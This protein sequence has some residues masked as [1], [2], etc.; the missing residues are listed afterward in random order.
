MANWLEPFT[1]GYHFARVSRETGYE[2]GNVE[3]I[4]D[5]GSITRNVDT[6]SYE[7]GSFSYVGPLDL[8]NDLVRP[9]L[10]ATFEDGTRESVPLGTF[11][12]SLPSSDVSGAY[13]EGK[14][15]M[16]GRLYE[17]A[18]ARFTEPLR[19][20]KGSN[21][22]DV[23][24]MVLEDAG[25]EVIA[26]ESGYTLSQDWAVGLGSSDEDNDTM[27]GAVNELLGLAGFSSAR[28]DEYGRVLLRK[29]Y[30]PSERQPSY[31]FVEGRNARFL[32]QVTNE[33][34]L[35]DVA[36]VVLAVYSN[37]DSTV[38]GSARDDDPDSPTSTV[39]LG[40]ERSAKYRYNDLV[41]QDEADAK[42]RELLANQR[43]V[44]RRVTIQHVY[45]PTLRAGDIAGLEYPS[46]GISGGF[47]VRTQN[48]T[49]GGAAKTKTEL[50]RTERW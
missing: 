7:S 41:S 32:R 29:Y 2:V 23:A 45:V 40:W 39:S 19:I 15:D 26:D 33:R 11:V 43:S 50:K 37:Q 14:A 30:S 27:L 16:Y 24:R 28:T 25:L 48:V 13:S 3:G 10:D 18:S 6:A 8:G 34:D 22:V 12:V 36:N 21:A 35:S 46:A 9:Y 4:K 47:T 17:V 20:A 31:E 49:L 42:A 38:I 44:I 1:A 5:G